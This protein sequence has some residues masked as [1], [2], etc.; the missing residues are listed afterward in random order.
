MADVLVSEL[1]GM[2]V[3]LY[4]ELVLTRSLDVHV[5]R[6]PVTLLRHTLRTPVRPDT[7]FRVAIPVRAAVSPALVPVRLK[8]PIGHA[9]AKYLR[10]CVLR[11]S[12]PCDDGCSTH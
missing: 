11:H 12:S 4:M 9:P 6:V 5:S 1:R 7:E 3:G 8:R 10:I 2:T